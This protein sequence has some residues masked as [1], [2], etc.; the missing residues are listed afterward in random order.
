MAVT[1]RSGG[2]EGD[3]RRSVIRGRLV[4]QLLMDD[5]ITGLLQRRRRRRRVGSRHGDAGDREG[6]S[7][8]RASRSPERST[9]ATE[10]AAVG[11]P[12]KARED[13][14]EANQHEETPI[15]EDADE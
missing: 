14:V 8:G 10:D 5:R 13:G 3:R 2:L 15:H 12:E 9:A 11:A 7:S 4:R 1:G 6:G